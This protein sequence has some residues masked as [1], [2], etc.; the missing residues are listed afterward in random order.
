L[1]PLSNI[2]A[3]VVLHVVNKKELAAGW[4]VKNFMEG[5]G[6]LNLNGYA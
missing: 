6:E 1:S 5:T 4:R 2:S 3:S